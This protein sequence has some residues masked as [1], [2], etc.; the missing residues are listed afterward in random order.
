[1]R[2]KRRLQQGLGNA[3]GEQ[4]DDLVYDWQ[5]QLWAA[6]LLQDARCEAMTSWVNHHGKDAARRP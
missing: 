5:T 4:S 3:F 6:Q 2:E 1:M